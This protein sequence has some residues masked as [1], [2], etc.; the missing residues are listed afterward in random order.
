MVG[1]GAKTLQTGTNLSGLFSSVME[2]MMG[3][4][5][6]KICFFSG[7]QPLTPISS[8]GL[9]DLATSS[10]MIY[11]HRLHL[12][13]SKHRT[14]ANIFKNGT[15]TVLNVSKLQ[16]LYFEEGSME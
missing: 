9:K 15:N 3:S 5:T 10:R 11:N 1:G 14:S 12:L 6:E 8:E 7:L 2:K 4:P 13:S 16:G